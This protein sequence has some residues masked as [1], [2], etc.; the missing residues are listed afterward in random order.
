M[1]ETIF[2]KFKL[3]YIWA[4]TV[5][6]KQ[7]HFSETTFSKASAIKNKNSVSHTQKILTLECLNTKNLPEFW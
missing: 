1:L 2:E 6:Q 5:L 3:N 7:G 4:Q